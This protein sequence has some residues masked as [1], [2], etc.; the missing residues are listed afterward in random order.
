MGEEWVQRRKLTADERESLE[1]RVA[2][3]EIKNHWMSVIS[4]EPVGGMVFF[5]KL[6]G[7]TGTI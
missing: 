6:Y 7:N 4:I 2:I 1:N 3:K 5:L